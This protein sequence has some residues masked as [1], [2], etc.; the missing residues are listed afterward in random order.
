MVVILTKLLYKPIL[1]SLEERR[2]KIAAG[3][4]YEE[5]MK[6]ELEKNDKKLQEILTAAK[7]EAKKIVA[8]GKLGAKRL[9]S[10]IIDKAHKEAAVI[11]AKG[12]EDIEQEKDE[13]ERKLKEKTVVIAEEIVKRLLS[14]I[15]SEETQ[16]KIVDKK[17]SLIARR[18]K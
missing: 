15:L 17:L 5:K 3:L 6:R 4:A 11:L 14:D 16:K 2:K 8:E 7:T 12:K 13:M 10:E 9:E 18:I 1:R